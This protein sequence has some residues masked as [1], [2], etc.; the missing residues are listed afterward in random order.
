M[1]TAAGVAQKIAA[2]V[3]KSKPELVFTAGG[4][5][6]ALA[7]AISPRLVDWMMTMYHDDLIRR[8]RG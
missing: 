8:L 2:A 3:G 4:K 6:L 7:S 1:M 5:F